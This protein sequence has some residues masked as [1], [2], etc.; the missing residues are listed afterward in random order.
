MILLQAVES[1]RP[2]N[3]NGWDL[4]YFTEDFTVK[5]EE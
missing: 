1:Q 2:A 5:L 4:C 3:E